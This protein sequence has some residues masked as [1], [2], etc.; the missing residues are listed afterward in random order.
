MLYI[1]SPWSHGGRGT[2][3]MWEIIIDTA[4]DSWLPLIAEGLVLVVFGRLFAF[5]ALPIFL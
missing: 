1:Y 2:S 3:W 5:R 4:A